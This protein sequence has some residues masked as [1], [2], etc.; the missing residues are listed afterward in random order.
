M[1]SKDICD[2][3]NLTAEEKWRLLEGT[4]AF[5]KLPH[6]NRLN[7]TGHCWMGCPYVLRVSDD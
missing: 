3:S 4:D 6:Y 1:R 7:H 2:N 5:G